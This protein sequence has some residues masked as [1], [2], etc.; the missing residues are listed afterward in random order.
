MSSSLKRFSHNIYAALIIFAGVLLASAVS[1]TTAP[2]VDEGKHIINGAYYLNHG[3]CCRR[4]E[5]PF[6]ALHVL[7][8]ILD[9]LIV[10]QRGNVEGGIDFYLRNRSKAFRIKVLSRIFNV[11]AFFLICF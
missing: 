5:A 7:P 4:D 11:G 6:A 8:L 1:I 2:T 9:D 3:D 10:N